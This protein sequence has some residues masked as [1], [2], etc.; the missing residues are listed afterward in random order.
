MKR[1]VL[2]C[3]WW[4][5]AVGCA[6]TLQYQREDCPIYDSLEPIRANPA[7]APDRHLQVQVVFRVCPPQSGLEEIQRKRFELKHEVLVL[8]SSKT[9]QDLEDPLRVEKLQKEI[10]P[11]VNQKVLKKSR[12]VEVLVTGFELQ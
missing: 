11:L 2:C 5:L 3:L 10:L 7:G 12:V 8:L 1:L 4:T 6:G 9:A